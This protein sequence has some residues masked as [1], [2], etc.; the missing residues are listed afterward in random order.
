VGTDS[1]RA[2]SPLRLRL[3]QKKQERWNEAI[4]SIDFLHA[5]RKAWSTINKNTGRSRPS[6][7]LCSASANS[8]ASQLLKNGAHKAGDRESKR[9]F[10]REVSDGWNV[11][12]GLFMPG[13]HATAFTHL[14]LGKSL[15]LDYISPEFMLPPG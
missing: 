6:S 15:Q 4:N 3:D 13:E 1:H 14:E 12:S 2:A 9:L 8:T 7:C 5:S 10:N 11:P